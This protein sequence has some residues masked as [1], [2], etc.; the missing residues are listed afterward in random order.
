[1]KTI[2][3]RM[4]NPRGWYCHLTVNFTDRQ[5]YAR[6]WPNMIVHVNSD[7]G[8]WKIGWHGEIKA[9]GTGVE[10]LGKELEP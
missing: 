3:D 9:E 5:Y 7:T 1:M 6:D 8:G 4:L 10:S 2:F